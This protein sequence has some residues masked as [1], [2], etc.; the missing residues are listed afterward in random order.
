MIYEQIDNQ[1]KEAMLAR[2][3]V[4]LETLRGI[5]KE[6]LEAKTAKGGQGEVSDEKALEIIAKLLKQRK[7]SAEVYALNGRNDL[8][9]NERLEAKVLEEFLPKQLTREELVSIVQDKIKTL[10]IT[11][12]KQAGRLTGTL[13]KELKGQVDG[14]ILNE[15][16]QAQLS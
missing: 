16:I 5:K 11:D 4:R 6:L 13:M 12:P 10:G 1:I 7:E 15:V 3:K 14:K 9:E 8:A 2:D